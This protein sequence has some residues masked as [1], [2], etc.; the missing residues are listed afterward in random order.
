VL[1]VFDF[2]GTLVDSIHDLAE[3][4]TELS[5]ECGGGRL[6]DRTVTFMVGEG[7]NTLV[8]RILAQAG[9][10]G[11]QPGAL[12]HF[13]E[14]YDRRML[15]HTMPYAGMIETLTVVSRT[16]QLA[17]LTNKPEQA[18]RRIMTYTGLDRFFDDCVFGDGPH[19]RKPDPEGLRALMQ[20]H[21]AS[22]A[23][24]WMIGDSDVDIATARA[25]GVQM[26]VARYGFGFSR[27]DAAT[28]RDG[29]LLID[30]PEDMLAALRAG[31][32]SIGAGSS[33]PATGADD[34]S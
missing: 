30:R 34:F 10:D 5:L 19:P 6:D 11:P 24:T 25:A 3:S 1:L 18:T 20:R 15:D 14:I 21:S 32:S 13:L 27:I 33:G 17:M 8:E 28:L 16:H 4:A 7:A 29:D 22:P 12:G 9:V 2:D 31:S 26:C 23:T